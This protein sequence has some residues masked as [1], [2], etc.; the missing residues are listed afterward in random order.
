MRHIHGQTTAEQLREDEVF[1]RVEKGIREGDVD[2]LYET[3]ADGI[4][5]RLRE[6]LADYD[7]EAVGLIVTAI[8]WDAYLADTESDMDDEQWEPTYVGED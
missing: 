3:L 4:T 6:A 7:T 2:R 1:R 5:E 8:I